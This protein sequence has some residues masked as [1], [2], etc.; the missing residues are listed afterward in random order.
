MK[1]KINMVGGGFQHDVSSCANRIPEHIEWVKVNY[2]APISIHIDSGIID[3]PVDKTKK[4]THGC[5]NL[6]QSYLKF[7]TG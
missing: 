4:I 5:Q 3:T 7:T 2:T 6:K 1:Q